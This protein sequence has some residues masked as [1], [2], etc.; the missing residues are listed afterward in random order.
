MSDCTWTGLA[1]TSGK[2]QEVTDLNGEIGSPTLHNIGKY[3]PDAN[4]SW[5]INVPE[6]M[7]SQLNQCQ[8]SCQIIFSPAMVCGFYRGYKVYFAVTIFFVVSLR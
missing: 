1:C 2:P 3:P 4:C 7:V 8:Y 6:W 5:K